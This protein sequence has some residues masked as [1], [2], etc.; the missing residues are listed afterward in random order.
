MGKRPRAV[1]I[2]AGIGGLCTALALQRAGWETVLCEQAPALREAGAGIV[3]AANAMHALGELGI[4]EAV[5]RKGA[6]VKT[7]D[8]RSWEGDLLTRLPVDEQAAIYG[9]YSYLIHRAA[10]QSVLL[11]AMG[12]DTE[13]G[14]GK[15]CVGW[16]EHKEGITA[17]FADGSELQGN[18]LIGA[19]GLYSKVREKLFGLSPLRYSGY[20]ALRGICRLSGMG[21][22]LYTSSAGGGFEAWGPGRRFGLSHLGDGNVFWFSAVNGPENQ[23]IPQGFR[24]KTALSLFRGWYEPVLEAIRATEEEA[25]L[26]HDIYDRVPL[27]QWGKGRVTLVGD[28]A[29]PMLPNLG[30]GGAQ[31]MEDALVLGRHLQIAAADGDLSRLPQLLRAYE[32]ARIPRTNAVVRGSRRMAKLVQLELPAAI[33]A[34]NA[35]L[36]IM[37]APVQVRRLDWLLGFR[38]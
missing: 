19:D 23:I 35:A 38:A 5:R 34:R 15:Q 33:A 7:A 14:Y 6:A 8:I 16:T 18:L 13:I 3:L 37:P 30:Q 22:G 12:E 17:V 24:K 11:E 29:H 20:H 10:L 25:I 28:A 36:R 9:T 4:A 1:L 2:G 27:P 21:E 26:S 31:A 32:R